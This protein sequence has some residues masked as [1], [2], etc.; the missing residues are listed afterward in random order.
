MLFIS[1]ESLVTQP[2]NCTVGNRYQYCRKLGFHLSKNR[3]P[4]YRQPD[5]YQL[6]HHQSNYKQQNHPLND[7]QPSF[8]QK[9]YRKQNYNQKDHKHGYVQLDR[10][11]NFHQ[12]D[13]KKDYHQIKRKQDYHQSTYS[14]Q[15]YRPKKHQQL[16][17]DKAKTIFVIKNE[18]EDSQFSESENS[19]SCSFSDDDDCSYS[20]IQPNNANSSNVIK[21]LLAKNEP[22]YQSISSINDRI[23]RIK[24]CDR[25]TEHPNE[26]A[27]TSIENPPTEIIYQLEKHPL[28]NNEDR[29]DLIINSSNNLIPPN[30]D[31]HPIFSQI[32]GFP[33]VK[34]N[35]SLISV[36]DRIIRIERCDSVTEKPH[37]QALISLGH[38]STEIIYQL[39]QRPL[40]DKE[41]G[42][43]LLTS[44]PSNL[45]QTNR[46][47]HYPLGSGDVPPVTV[48]QGQNS[49]PI[50]VND[51]I[52]RIERYDSI[53]D[54]L[55]EQH[56]TE[57]PTEI[58]YLL[59]QRPPQDKENG[60]DL[61]A[62]SPS[63]LIQTNRERHYPLR[64]G[65]I[66]PVTVNQDENPSPI[67]VN[68]RIIRIERYD[69]IT[70]YLH[71]QHST[72]RPTEVIYQLEQRPLQNKENGRNLLI[73]SSSNSHPTNRERHQFSSHSSK[74]LPLNVDQGENPSLISV[75]DRII[76]IERC[77]S[78]TEKPHE[79]ASISFGHPLTEVIYQL[80][81]YPMQNNQDGQDLVTSSSN[82][83]IQTN[84]ERY[85][86][87]HSEDDPPVKVSQGENPP[88]ITV[89]DRI[90]RI[91][92]CDSVTEDPEEQLSTE[93][94]TETIYQ[95]KQP[96]PQKN[97]N[98]RDFKIY[99]SSNL[100]PA[101]RERQP[102]LS[103]S[104][105]VPPVK[106]GQDE[107]P[108]L[109]PVND[110]II[111]IER[112]DNV[113]NRSYEQLSIERP[114]KVIYQ[115]EQSALRSNGD[116]RDL[117]IFSSSN[118]IPPNRERH[119]F[120]SQHLEVP[121][122]NV[123]LGENPSLISANDRIIRIERCDSVTEKPHEQ[124]SISIG[125]PSTKI[126]YQ[127]EQHPLQDKEDGRDLLTNSPNKLIPTNRESHHFS[128]HSSKVPPVNVDQGENPSLL[129]VNDQIIRI[130]RCDSVTEKPHEQASFS[131][132]RP[133][134]EVIH[135]L[136]QYPLQSNGNR[137]DLSINSPSNQI[138]INRERHHFS[139]H[140]LEIPSV[141]VDQGE[142]PSLLSVNDRIIRIERCDSVTEKL[143]EQASISI[144]RPSTEVIHKLDQR[145]LQNNGDRR[146]LSI[147]SSSNQIPYNS[148]RSKVRHR[149]DLSPHHKRTS[150]NKKWNKHCSKVM[151]PFTNP[152]LEDILEEEE[153]AELFYS[154]DVYHDIIDQ[155]RDKNKKLSAKPSQNPPSGYI[156]Q[157]NFP[158][159]NYNYFTHMGNS[160]NTSTLSRPTEKQYDDPFTVDIMVNPYAP[161]SEIRYEPRSSCMYR[162]CQNPSA[163]KKVN[164]LP[165]ITNFFRSSNMFN[166]STVAQHHGTHMF[167]ANLPTSIS[168]E[169]LNVTNYTESSY[170]VNSEMR[171]ND[172]N[173]CITN[174]NKLCSTNNT[175]LG[176]LH[177]NQGDLY[178]IIRNQYNNAVIQNDASNKLR[179]HVF[180]NSSTSG[181]QLKG[182]PEQ[183]SIPHV[184]DNW[185]SQF[186]PGEVTSYD[187]DNTD[188]Q[189]NASVVISHRQLSDNNASAVTCLPL[190][191]NNSP[192]DIG[193][194]LP[195][196]SDKETTSHHLPQNNN[197]VITDHQL[198]KNNAPVLTTHQLPENNLIA[199]K[200]T[201][202]F[203]HTNLQLENVENNRDKPDITNL[204]NSDITERK[205][206]SLDSFELFSL[207][208]LIASCIAL[209]NDINNQDLEN[210]YNNQEQ[211]YELNKQDQ[212]SKFNKQDDISSQY[213]PYEQDGEKDEFNKQNQGCESNE[214]NRKNEFNQ[215]CGLN[216]YD[217]ECD[218]DEQDDERDEL[219]EQDQG[220]EL[221]NQ[222]EQ[223]DSYERYNEKNE[224]NEQGQACRS[225]EQN[226]R[227]E[228][229]DHDQG[230]S[231]NNQGT[232]FYFHEQD[233]EKDV[234]NEQCQGCG[235]NNQ[236][237]SCRF[238][239]KNEES[240]FYEQDDKKCE[241]NEQDQDFWRNNH[242]QGCN[243]QDQGFDLNDQNKCCDLNEN[244]EKRLFY[245]T[246]DDK[247]VFNDQDQ[248]CEFNK[249]GQRHGYNKQDELDHKSLFNKK[250]E[251]CEFFELDQ[252]FGFN[253]QDRGY[254]FCEKDQ[255]RNLNERCNKN[256]FKEYEY[257][258]PSNANYE[259]NQRFD[260]IKQTQAN[261]YN[262]YDICNKQDQRKNCNKQ[263]QRNEC[264]KHQIGNDC[265]SQ[266]H[267]CSYNKHDQC[268]GSYKQNEWFGHFQLDRSCKI[269]REQIDV[270]DRQANSQCKQTMPD[271]EESTSITVYEITSINSK[272]STAMDVKESI[273]MTINKG[274][275]K[276]TPIN[277]EESMSINSEESMSMNTKSTSIN[278]EERSTSMN[279][280]EIILMSPEETTSLNTAKRT[281]INTK[282]SAAVNNEERCSKN[283]E[284]STLI[285]TANST[286]MNNSK[287]TSTNAQ[288]ST[289][290]NTKEFFGESTS[291]SNEEI[292]L[293][294]AEE[295]TSM[296]NEKNILI[297]TKSSTS[298]HTEKSTSIN[299]EDSIS[300]QTEE[301][302][303]INTEDST[304]IHSDES[305][306]I[307]TKE[308]ISIH[309]KESILSHT[310]ES[311]S[312]H[313][314]KMTSINTEALSLVNTAQAER[315]QKET[316]PEQ[317]KQG[318][319]FEKLAR[320][321]SII[322]MQ[323]VHIDNLKGQVRQ[324]KLKEEQKRL[325]NVIQEQ[326]H[327]LD[328]LQISIQHQT[329]IVTNKQSFSK[330]AKHNNDVNSTLDIS[331]NL[332][333]SQI[334]MEV[335]KDQL[336]ICTDLEEPTVGS[337]K[338]NA[339]SENSTN[340]QQGIPEHRKAAA[341]NS[342][343][344]SNL[345]EDLI[346]N[347]QE[348]QQNEFYWNDTA[349]DLSRSILGNLSVHAVQKP[350]VLVKDTTL[351]LEDK[352]KQIHPVAD[353]LFEIIQLLQTFN[354]LYTSLAAEKP[355]E[356]NH[357]HSNSIQSN[358]DNNQSHNKNSAQ[359]YIPSLVSII[360]HQSS[361][362]GS[363][364][365]QAKH[366]DPPNKQIHQQDVLIDQY[367]EHVMK[368]VPSSSKAS[369]DILQRTTFYNHYENIST[370]NLSN[371]SINQL[372]QP[373]KKCKRVTFANN[374][375]TD[376]QQNCSLKNR[377]NSTFNE[378][379]GVHTNQYKDKKKDTVFSSENL[380]ELDSNQSRINNL[381][382]KHVGIVRKN[383]CGR[384]TYEKKGRRSKKSSSHK[385]AEDLFAYCNKNG[386]NVINKDLTPYRRHSNIETHKYAKEV[387]AYCNKNG[388]N[389]ITKDFTPKR[390]FA[391][392]IKEENQSNNS[393]SNDA[394]TEISGNAIGNLSLDVVQGPKVLINDTK[395]LLN[396]PE[397]LIKDT[398]ALVQE[399]LTNVCSVDHSLSEITQ[400]VRTYSNWNASMPV[401]QFDKPC[402]SLSNDKILHDNSQKH[403][404]NNQSHDYENFNQPHD[405]H[406]MQCQ[407]TN[408]ST[409][410]VNQYSSS[411]N[412]GQ[413]NEHI[414][415]QVPISAKTPISILR[416][417][418]TPYNKQENNSLCNLSASQITQ[419]VPP[420]KKRKHVT[421][422]DNLSTD[423][424]I[425]K[426][427][428]LTLAEEPGMN[429][430]YHKYQNGSSERH[431][432]MASRSSNNLRMKNT[433]ERKFRKTKKSD[434][435]K[436]A[437][438]LFA[439]CNKNDINII[440]KDLTPYRRHSNIETHKYAKEVFAYC[441]KNGIN[442]ITKD[443]T[444]KRSFASCIKEENQSNNS[445]SNDATTEISGN[446]IGNLSLDVVQGPKVLINDTKVFL[447][448]PEV[449]IKDTK[450]LVQEKLTNV[451]S[452]AHS[453]S[454]TS[455]QVRT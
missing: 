111:K 346:E 275:K 5:S 78:V 134:T 45:I 9:E 429:T 247:C 264:E 175:Q 370:G 298:I 205:K 403:A 204:Q 396:E 407:L 361:S 176:K 325:I 282:E 136:E 451:C 390:S 83:L 453:L 413:H 4:D 273:S 345:S 59:E 127:L 423:G 12:L 181:T 26:Q 155:L 395:V 411:G 100:I 197:A 182:K 189:N 376:V 354:N 27:Q 187:F 277:S 119:H 216:N 420:F 221:N 231:F 53:T 202:N 46:E 316:M 252:E 149:F 109:I 267:V 418:T 444:P 52:I 105:N 235:F 139:L 414:M 213:E 38:P 378:K 193:H 281:S 329:K 39:E 381:Q 228:F 112:Y 278:S 79:Q 24:R 146:D 198:S 174:S 224:F 74:V 18:P 113:T 260:Y 295:N 279:I 455:Q 315:H 49:S 128:L 431:N 81:Q 347:L 439:F 152:T 261:D 80:K 303:S 190:Q 17:N 290:M 86:P 402:H 283:T 173:S 191:Q 258:N 297:K 384:N 40:Q 422:T 10:K 237:L 87:L 168:H 234:F 148:E 348:Y 373:S 156:R 302:T 135:K 436:F 311:I 357:S 308:S 335:A 72:E 106:V 372:I 151:R 242:D 22:Q 232:E 447:N 269:N 404:K 36:N 34:E 207:E 375:T 243:E 172:D 426:Q 307:N 367:D 21:P 99:S 177:C 211:V 121:P 170:A 349:T 419:L 14:Q 96:T 327:V 131:I 11:Q 387:F 214:Q 382:Y 409:G 32:L 352:N 93:R 54:H 50:T 350:K 160:Q 287:T 285:R 165:R 394:T 94:P 98:G 334:S 363:N 82:N 236:N 248:G 392:C 421:F 31:C 162:S 69:S 417:A 388:I 220:C 122:V 438:D 225:N 192:A 294:N 23:I 332:F 416:H 299:T 359:D 95:L 362:S 353:T 400:Q 245:E 435:H 312:S 445:H 66:P 61:L 336:T 271:S 399:K 369:G 163:V 57:R 184:A 7:V 166:N 15:K 158:C 110:R 43:D 161:Y 169:N 246:V 29:R 330:A 67:T 427:S 129:S 147:N 229:N 410:S 51:R 313:A 391:S 76:R 292:I 328:I 257:Y 1:D 356:L 355:N 212:E 250:A 326:L 208:K 217:G 183:R 318:N 123:D 430:N 117:K 186:I 446:V 56:S 233:D 85:F 195:K 437:E 440:N 143:H 84:K 393:H 254:G 397:V 125:R 188:S 365:Q 433:F 265:N 97:G 114:T 25:V 340:Q 425:Q 144:G 71:E 2:E 310:E 164:E 383:L 371:S 133:S 321:I 288:E 374:L 115:L 338:L 424:T 401:K 230:C 291:V 389:V 30:K 101:N 240:E 42:R 454:E 306:L 218:S 408:P 140:S 309:N 48:N 222:S 118:L 194:Q 314:E 92:R 13:R 185:L 203:S 28:Q 379:L 293:T 366:N 104:T 358:Q 219:N 47:R 91:E 206:L 323:L 441:N 126:I 180:N 322:K 342:F 58:I 324:T 428:K 20:R 386:I 209:E 255:G 226:Q 319:S 63:N 301:S 124:A 157:E 154:K 449:L 68:D 286:A 415:K 238:G 77:D 343:E 199:V 262:E 274:N 6:N 150:K 256:K 351:L 137:R 120:L 37:E 276:T 296:I 244:E 41:D 75:N 450:A 272:E 138:P 284:D 196:N 116:E 88:L 89:N 132:G 263:N 200:S 210:E 103:Y 70:D 448:E 432:F 305:I 3:E 280:E 442:V 304:S 145:S 241:F 153:D 178:D 249:Q 65:D 341:I 142:N 406:V 167:N 289:S 159:G 171:K 300:V 44:S 364:N 452:I 90:I 339:M 398:K 259:Q 380:N 266:D 333:S 107:N 270:S 55:H 64:S 223:R 434:S 360:E 179:T 108:S 385:F 215:D 253:E 317:I 35:P 8:P 62:N 201:Q 405:I 60:Q 268:F 19:N 73:N 331:D 227:C 320:L 239:E 141:N 412:S 443:F 368:L 33:P 337:L 377:N 16:P 102:V 344:S 130:E 251:Q